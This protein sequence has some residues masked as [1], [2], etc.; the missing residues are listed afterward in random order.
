M[1]L[2]CPIPGPSFSYGNW[3][4]PTA[5]RLRGLTN[6]AAATY[7]ILAAMSLRLIAAN[8]IERGL[9]PHPKITSP[10]GHAQPKAIAA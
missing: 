4:H 8:R 1:V 10:P 7:G 6:R 5:I 2:C 3:N 9:P